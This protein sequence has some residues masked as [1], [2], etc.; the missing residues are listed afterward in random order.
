[1]KQARSLIVIGIPLIQTLLLSIGVIFESYY[2]LCAIAAFVVSD[3]LLYFLFPS[4]IARMTGAALSAPPILLFISTAGSLMFVD[5][6]FAIVSVI[7]GNAIFVG[8]Y[9][10]A[11]PSRLAGLSKDAT[12]TSPIFIGAFGM[13]L[14]ALVFM[15]S[16]LLFALLY[17]LDIP[18]WMTMIPYIA[19]SLSVV[20]IYF[21]ERGL[22]WSTILILISVA[23]VCLIEI[24]YSLTWLPLSYLPMT[25]F[26]AIASIV[27]FDALLDY[28]MK[29]TLPAAVIMLVLIMVASIWR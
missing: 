29:Y 20:S 1:M 21:H 25:A 6:G 22:Q 16:L 11:L 10:H 28:R 2:I 15:L 3:V 5:N 17:F 9:L 12:T 4:S 26:V 18:I 13:L 19:I 7:A 14:I 8:T 27:L 23:A 24:I